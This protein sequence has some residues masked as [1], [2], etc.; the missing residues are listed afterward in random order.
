MAVEN[1]EVT[2]KKSIEP[3]VYLFPRIG[4][5]RDYNDATDSQAYRNDINDNFRNL[6]PSVVV[7]VAVGASSKASDLKVC[8]HTG[9]D[10]SD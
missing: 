2:H 6:F 1:L 8:E 3:V 5:S 7:L 9:Q 4:Y 10:K